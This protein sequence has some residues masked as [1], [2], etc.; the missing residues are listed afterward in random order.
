MLDPDSL[1]RPNV[2]SLVPYS[3][4]RDEFKGKEGVFL[5]AN[6]N[7]YGYLN[8][9]PDP[10]QKDLKIA[11]SKLKAIPT[12][13]IFLG[14]GSDEIIDLTFRIFCNPGADK[15]LTFSPSY[16]MY[17]VS[18]SVNDVS[19][20]KIPL[21]KD[22]QID[23]ENV[24]KHFSDKNLKIIIICSPNNPTGNLM[25]SETVERIISQFHGIVLV[26]EAYM[27]FAD[28]PSLLGKL[29]AYPNLIVMQTFSKAFGLASARVGVA[30]TNPEIIAYYN[31]L[32]PPYNIS[33]LNQKAVLQ[34]LTKFSTYTDQIRKIRKEKER[35]SGELKKNPV[36]QKVYPS[37]A[38]F[39][40]IKVED[41]AK[42]YNYLVDN[43]IVVRNRHS[44]IENC[45]RI[46]VGTR[47]EN[48]KLLTALNNF[49]K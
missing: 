35:L 12:E 20:I 32:K 24:K 25:N 49:G 14:N 36:I 11:I 37:D 44:V 8:R 28:K 19:I 26:D 6:E 46:T 7:P 13:K 41:S 17:Q 27:D 47:S 1:V 15:A 34:K 33:S 9:Y 18:A 4:A 30:Y 48:N 40:L 29:S 22:F 10:Y 45:I 23:F 43:R 3:C 16:G 5:D 42:L 21:D 2:K 39:V 38:N 31:K